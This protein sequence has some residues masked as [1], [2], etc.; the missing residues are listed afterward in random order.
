MM[1]AMKRLD[2]NLW[3]RCWLFVGCIEIALD[4]VLRVSVRLVE[5]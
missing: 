4:T 2:A 3:G 1:Q 5:A